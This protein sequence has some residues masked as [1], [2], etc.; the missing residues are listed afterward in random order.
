MPLMVM[1]LSAQAA[2][3]PEGKPV[4][5]PMP[6]ATEVLCVILVNGVLIQTVGVIEAALA[7]TTSFTVIVPVA[8]T[9]P[10]APVKGIE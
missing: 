10:Q 2:V 5:D 3:T 4:G 8:F 1:V 9:E 7:V 6:V